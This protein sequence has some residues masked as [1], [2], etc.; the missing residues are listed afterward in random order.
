[1][2]THFV[3]SFGKK[4]AHLNCSVFQPLVKDSTNSTENDGMESSPTF[5]SFHNVA[6]KRIGIEYGEIL[7]VT[8]EMVGT[9]VF[10][11]PTLFVMRHL[12]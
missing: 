7:K 11:K 8:E 12:F 9:I 1:M 2:H 3:I 10:N 4:F 6:I 5:A